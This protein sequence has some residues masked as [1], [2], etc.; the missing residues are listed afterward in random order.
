[1]KA[2]RICILPVYSEI[3]PTCQI[4]TV[5][6]LKHQVETLEAFN[7]PD[8]DIIF[9]TAMTGDGKSLAGY[10]PVLQ[11]QKHVIAMYP[12]NELMRDQHRGLSLYEQNLKISLP[13][14]ALMDS[15]EIN[16]L[17]REHDQA[18]RME[19]VRSLVRNNEILLTNPDLV[20]LMMSWQY[21]WQHQRKE[22]PFEIGASFDYFLFDEFHSVMNMVG[23]L[24]T[25]YKDKSDDRKKFLFL[26]ATP[27]KLLDGLLE[28]GGLRYKKIQGH[29]SST[30]QPDTRCIL[31]PCSLELHAISQES[32][33]EVWIE[34]HIESILQ[35]FQEHQHDIVRP[36]AA[37]LVYSVATARRLFK[38]LK[39][40]LEEP[41]GITIGENTGWTYRDDRRAS[42][43]KDILVGTSTIDIGVDFRINYLIF[44][45]F[46]AG[47]FLQRFG[48][49]GRHEGFPIYRAYGLVPGFVLERLK[50]KYGD[51][52]DVERES[53]NETIREAFP[54]ET[55]FENYTR[56]W[57]VLQAAH[58]LVELHRQ[59]DENTAFEAS[60]TE[61]YD[62]QYASPNYP[63]MSKTVKKYWAMSER[64]PQ[65]IKEL[66]SF[67]GQSPLSC[68]VWD[69]DGHLKTY[70]LFFPLTNTEFEWLSEASF[71]QEVKLRG[72]EERDF[73]QQL[74]YLKVLAY[75]PERLNLVLGLN[76]DLGEYTN[77]I[78]QITVLDTIFVREPHPIWRDKVNQHLKTLKLPCLLSDRVRTEL[79]QRLRLGAMFPLYRLHD[80]TGNEYSIAFGQDALLL[81]SLLYFYKT[82]GDKPLQL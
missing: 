42:F 62:Q 67:R 3:H 22:L 32:P 27:S 80:S 77:T 53:F 63:I 73:K 2:T 70:D 56:R 6:L 50:Q 40:Y 43:E 61:Q 64:Q 34:E 23:Y 19:A 39:K 12:T 25:L 47:S 46:N 78:H 54:T 68:G 45:A 71:M 5:N 38:L 33:T 35:F 16:R 24:H 10:L 65:I 8:I 7:N 17:M 72:L 18:V 30:I 60:L 13:R 52:C 20:H 59:K 14:T 82:R 66:L 4:G 21:G 15:D 31:Q 75:I 79:K 49:L 11:E 74:L 81:E 26:S 76:Y 55:E 58:V 28:R 41:Y 51:E 57:G 36:K 69:T 48:R 29:Y 44:E 37:V 9:N 1:M